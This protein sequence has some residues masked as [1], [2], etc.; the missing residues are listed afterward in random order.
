M[1]DQQPDAEKGSDASLPITRVVESLLE[2]SLEMRR[3]AADAADDD[4]RKFYTA[5]AVAYEQW[6]FQM[7]SIA[8]LQ[9]R[10]DKKNGMIK[11]RFPSKS[12]QGQAV[13]IDEYGG[14]EASS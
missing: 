14:R 4:W 3:R 2:K 6:S 10:I 12:Q 5:S 7:Q 9:T 1:T 13:G 8:S 11:H